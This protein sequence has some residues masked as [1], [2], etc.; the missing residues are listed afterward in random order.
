MYDIHFEKYSNKL[1]G[2]NPLVVASKLS[3]FNFIFYPR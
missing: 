1:M 2:A 3:Q